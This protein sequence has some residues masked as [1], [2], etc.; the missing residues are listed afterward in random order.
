[1]QWDRK[2]EPLAGSDR[3]DVTFM[4]LKVARS[5]R[6]GAGHPSLGGRRSSYETRLSQLETSFE[7]VP[8]GPRGQHDG[9]IASRR[10]RTG[11]LDQA[12][13]RGGIVLADVRL[14]ELT[15][16]S[17]RLRDAAYVRTGCLAS[18]GSWT[19]SRVKFE[20]PAPPRNGSASASPG[21]PAC[22]G[23]QV[24]L[25]RSPCEGLPTSTS[26]TWGWCTP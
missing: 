5:K 26:W 8:V 20:R 6:P 7:F 15:I 21:C 19:G 25:K 3:G 18:R 24:G 2:S 12:R 17:N 22:R 4:E 11:R 10:R 14:S 13:R 23:R 1:M 16:Q 9:R